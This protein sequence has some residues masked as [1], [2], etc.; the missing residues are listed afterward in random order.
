MQEIV[1][2]KGHAKLTVVANIVSAVILGQLVYSELIE[3]DV[4]GKVTSTR[5]FQAVDRLN[6]PNE[7]ACAHIAK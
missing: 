5:C 2:L 1:P 7:Q 6:A 4:T 3:I